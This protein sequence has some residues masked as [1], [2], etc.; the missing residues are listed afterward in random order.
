MNRFEKTIWL[1]ENHIAELEKKYAKLIEAVNY[2]FYKD[3]IDKETFDWLVSLDPTPNKAYG[4]WIIQKVLNR[5]IIPFMTEFNKNIEKVNREREIYKYTEPDAFEK[6][7][8]GK[9]PF[10]EPFNTPFSI[11]D[12]DNISNRIYEI[13]KDSYLLKYWRGLENFKSED[14]SKVTNNLKWYD[15]LK[16][17]KILTPEE[18]NIMNIKGFD[19][20]FELVWI[21]HADITEKLHDAEIEKNEIDVWY[22]DADWKVVIP[23]TK[24]AA[25][26]VGRGTNWCTAADD[27]EDSRV[28]NYY[29]KY[30]RDD[31]PNTI[32]IDIINKTG[33]KPDNKWQIHF[34]SNQ[35]M[36]YG[37]T[38]VGEANEC[39]WI[40]FVDRTFPLEVKK[41]IFEHTHRFMFNPK[42]ALQVEA[43]LNNPEATAI[44]KKWFARNSMS[45]HKEQ[46]NNIT[47]II[48]D[49]L[50][51]HAYMDNAI[52]FSMES[53]DYGYDHPSYYLYNVEP[54]NT[55]ELEPCEMCQGIGY[56]LWVVYD[57]KYDVEL[58]KE[59]Y[60]ELLEIFKTKFPELVD[61]FIAVYPL[62]T[63]GKY[64]PNDNTSDMENLM[65][66]V[67]QKCR[68]CQ[69]KGKKE[70]DK[71]NPEVWSKEQRNEAGSIFQ[72]DNLKEGANEFNS[73]FS[74]KRGLVLL[75]K[76]GDNIFDQISME[77]YPDESIITVVNLIN[78]YGTIPSSLDS[79][80]VVQNEN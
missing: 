76:I 14:S 9:K 36:D 44:L 69:G 57:N 73:N 80:G 65:K 48:N 23:K 24:L 35:F 47:D 19:E 63:N 49:K 51:L 37:D 29:Y 11:Y 64:V 41:T 3:K 68:F 75:D 34:E 39:T 53:Y 67:N 62:N 12:F 55:E 8:K 70:F 27:T 43:W 56:A 50:Y 28:M 40:D 74:D 18:S 42:K 77:Y 52:D 71:E 2:D 32:L 10:L 17:K 25:I 1:R 20:L 61:E 13:D 7:Y 58:T 60:D 31:F 38:D 78:L 6:K 46:F 22:E 16:N 15:K 4:K 30:T 5:W 59:K 21:D 66:K 45:D 54:E 33:K 72:N 79:F 26:A